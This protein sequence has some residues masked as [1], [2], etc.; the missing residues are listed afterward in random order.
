MNDQLAGIASV[1]ASAD[2]KPTSQ[3]YQVYDEIAPQ[4]DANIKKLDKIIAS[5]VYEFNKLVDSKRTPAI[6]LETKPLKP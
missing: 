2:T 1:A 4:I 5:Q 3:T 6:K